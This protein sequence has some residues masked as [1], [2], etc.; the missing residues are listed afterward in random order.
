M[1]SDPITLQNRYVIKK[2][3]ILLLVDFGWWNI[4]PFLLLLNDSTCSST[5]SSNIACILIHTKKL[6]GDGRKLNR[7]DVST[8]GH[9]RELHQADV[10]QVAAG[11]VDWNR[12]NAKHLHLF[13]KCKNNQLFIILAAALHR[14][15]L[16]M[17]IVPSNIAS[18]G[19]YYCG[20]EPLATL[21]SISPAEMRTSELKPS[22]SRDECVTTGLIL[23]GFINC[24]RQAYFPINLNSFRNYS[25]T[26]NVFNLL[27]KKANHPKLIVYNC[28]SV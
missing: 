4:Q 7:H 10:I 28:L 14:S 11:C 3:Q 16:G 15:V 25:I 19:K 8:C 18:F 27:D 6:I 22:Y 26:T 12:K 17:L 23:T 1:K 9:R 13:M 5:P 20:S 24:R 21:R 2:L